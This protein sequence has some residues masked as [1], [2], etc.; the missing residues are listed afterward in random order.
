MNPIYIDDLVSVLLASLGRDGHETVNMGGDEVVGVRELASRI[1]EA[2][3][4][5]AW[6]EEGMV[7]GFG[8]LVGDMILLYELYVSVGLVSFDEGLRR[9]VVSLMVE[10]VLV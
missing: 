8:D 1:A 6:F 3:G 5:E 4:I 2:I 9:I 10:E 7:E